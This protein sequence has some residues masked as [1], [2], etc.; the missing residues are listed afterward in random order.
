MSDNKKMNILMIMSDEQRKDTL[1]CYGNGQAT[2]PNIDKL[3]QNSTVFDMC[4]TPYPLC[5]PARA[6]LFTGV[7]THKHNVAG[8]WR[9]IN[10]KYADG[11]LI[12]IFNN[13]GYHTS[14]TG[15]WHIPGT[16]PERMG[17]S[18]YNAIPD[19]IDGRDRGRYISEYRQYI[20]NLGYELKPNHIENL[21][22]KDFQA[23]KQEGK[24][25]CA[26]SEIPLEHYLETWQT[27]KFFEAMC[28]RDKDKPFFAVCSYNAPH[29]PMVVPAPYDTI[30]KPED[31]IL[32]ENFMSGIEGKPDEV[33]KSRY[34]KEGLELDEY[35]WRKLIAYY[36]GFCSLIDAQVGKI[37]D[38]LKTHGELDN[39][40][41]VY[42][43][44]HGDMM[45]SHG[46]IKK[47]Y[48]MHYDE[49]INVPLIISHPHIKQVKNYDGLISLI[50]ILPTL[51]KCAG[52]EEQCNIDGK[53]YSAIWSGDEN[54]SPREFVISETFKTDGQES[55]NGDR[56]DI[57]NFD[58]K[59][60]SA[61]LSIRTK[62]FKYIFH[63]DDIDELYHLENDKFEDCNLIADK[64]YSTILLKLKKKLIKSITDETAKFGETISHKILKEI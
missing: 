40:M 57:E 15:K 35:E 42:T 16:T 64:K 28:N 53:S 55:G 33:I 13:A 60:D 63:S 26:A 39:T 5:C 58:I 38:Y 59:K 24:A 34:M 4:Y 61:N 41:I 23:I 30:I 14:Y 44:D 8:N 48:P 25:P 17:F 62:N 22:E 49:D 47:G 37:I 56:I 18:Y 7:M 46:L 43:S 54:I 27:E 12:S 21:T 29:F 20:T 10:E 32:P 52:I 45:G 19:V 2:T 11:D 6:S 9:L 1:G 36:W 3:A 50:D 31:V 51:A